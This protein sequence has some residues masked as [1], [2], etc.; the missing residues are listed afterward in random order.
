MRH[1]LA[2]FLALAWAGSALIPPAAAETTPRT[3]ALAAPQ[4][5]RANTVNKGDCGH[6]FHLCPK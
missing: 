2:A 4:T 1:I 3:K 6:D 5:G